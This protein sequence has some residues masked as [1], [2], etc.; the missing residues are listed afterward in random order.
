MVL[1]ALLWT[2]PS[3]TANELTVCEGTSDNGYVPFHF[4]YLD[5]AKC[6]T[7]VIYPATILSEM[8]GNQI[9]EIQFYLNDE[10]YQTDWSTS[11]M[12]VSLAEC[13]EEAFSADEGRYTSFYTGT[14]TTVYS[15]PTEGV[16][17]GKLLTFKLTAPYHYK[18]GNLLL[19]ISLGAAGRAY[20]KSKFLGV[21]TDTYQAAYTTSGGTPYAEQF[22]P[23]TTFTYGEMAQYEA[24]VSTKDI[25]FP[26]TMVGSNSKSVVTVSNTGAQ[27]LN[28]SIQAPESAFSASLSANNLASGESMDIPV[29]FTPTQSG[30]ATGELVIDLGQAGTHR[31]AL[32]G[33]GMVPP[34]GFTSNFDVPSKSL[35]EGWTGWIITDTFDNDLNDYK[36]KSAKEGCEYFSSFSVDGRKGS[37]VNFD[38][39]ARDYPDRYTVYMI[40]PAVEGNVMM[41]LAA[42]KSGESYG[43]STA[44]VY[45][46]TKSADGSW[47]LSESPLAFSW[48][49]EPGSGWGVMI[50]SVAEPTHLAICLSSMGIATLAAD[51]GASTETGKD[52]ETSVSPQSIDF[53][54]VVVGK[55]VTK[56]IVVSNTG[57]KP[58]TVTLDATKEP[59]FTT[60]MASPTVEPGTEATIAVTFAPTTS[61]EFSETLSIS[62]GDAGN[63]GVTLTGKAV[64]AVVGAEFTVDGL[65]YT[66]TSQSEAGVS[67]VA[68]DITE[69]EVPATVTNPDG[70]ELAVTSIER[71][72]FY[73]SNVVKATL[74][75][76]LRTIGYGAFRTSDLAEINI[77]ATVT[78]IGNF[79]F[80]STKLKS[81]VI[82]DGVESIGSSVFA[83]CEQLVSVKLPKNLKSIGSGAFYKTALTKIEVPESCITIADEAFE[84]CTSLNEIN[85]PGGMT[86]ISSMLFLG[87]KSLT[88]LTIPASVVEIKTRALEETGLT[89]LH[90]PANVAKIASSTFN[91]TPIETITVDQQNNSFKVVGGILYDKTGDFLYLCPRRSIAETIKIEDGCRGIIGGAFYG[92]PV[93]NVELPQSMLG[94]D[95]YAFCTSELEQINLP[96]NIFLIST[97]A[98]AGT[99]L[100]DVTLPKGLEEVYDGLFA[101]CLNLKSVTLPA[102]VNLIGNLAFYGCTSLTEI[103]CEGETPAEF[104]AWEG[105]TEP[106]RGV[107]CSKVTVYC[108]D[109]DSVLADYKAS[110]WADFF[111]N[112]KNIS[113]RTSGVGGINVDSE[114][115]VDI[116]TVDGYRVRQ[117]VNAH[118]TDLGLPAGIYIVRT[119]S[120]SYKIQVK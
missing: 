56:D 57:R 71:E 34:T 3:I 61:G 25:T 104:D 113:D 52:Y 67:G 109:G 65:T 90:L 100:T 50:G 11:D 36:F 32:K 60:S 89:K 64:T 110:E 27:P 101:Q 24:S 13:S 48:A 98:F 76:G 75:E 87:C 30:E 51:S 105:L 82:P 10:G 43:A 106:F 72:A 16:G 22:Q 97:Q 88:Q 69:C 95:E 39:P 118:N 85:L 94:I 93:K 8:S 70:I 53:G 35:P 40:S 80:R 59:S 117:N 37:S 66:V 23:K 86:E 42:D 44:T 5:N 7:Q 83:S 96:D 91:G 33:N 99:K 26:T 41:E 19:Q 108:P 55:T 115:L 77:P 114:E 54:Q 31:I 4:Y 9:R 120:G 103:I 107:D 2:I 18:G 111:A 17:G 102:A 78:E 38:N 79:A 62:L 116:Y 49:S 73:W 47:R 21:Q 29:T 28:I 1:F 84:L 74:P 119:K 14:M 63:A 58:I 6:R 45:S 12:I 112:I 46:A 92:C 81:V 68:S 20:P 15:G